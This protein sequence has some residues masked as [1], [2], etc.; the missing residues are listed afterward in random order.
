MVIGEHKP[1][2]AQNR[3]WKDCIAIL[4]DEVATSL[5][6]SFYDLT[7]EQVGRYVVPN[8]HN[9]RTMVMHCIDNLDDNGVGTQTGRR[10]MELEDRFDMWSHSADEVRPLQTDTPTVQEMVEL[11]RRV[12]AALFAGLEAAGEVDLR[13]PRAAPDWWRRFGR[14]SG[15]AYLRTICHTLAHVRQIW[16]LRGAMGALGEVAWPQQHYA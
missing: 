12:R 10:L 15:D 1:K 9:I 7:G 2:E 5:E 16:A 3:C 14:T 13:G 6:E 8:R 11:L 4:L